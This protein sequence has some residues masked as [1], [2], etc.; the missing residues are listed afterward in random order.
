MICVPDVRGRT[1]KNVF[2]VHGFDV[3][4]PDH[5]HVAFRSYVIH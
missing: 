1:A 4:F 3:S 5:L 2:V